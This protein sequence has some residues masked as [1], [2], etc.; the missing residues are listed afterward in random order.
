MKQRSRAGKQIIWVC[1]VTFILMSVFAGCG[2]KGKQPEKET[3]QPEKVPDVHYE[4]GNV[5]AFCVDEQ[6]KI[7][8]CEE[9]T[10]TINVYDA[11][12]TKLGEIAVDGGTEAGS[13]Y[14]VL[15]A[16]EGVLYASDSVEKGIVAIDVTTGERELLYETQD[17]G[18]WSLLDM[19]VSNGNLYFIYQKPVEL[20][21]IEL[22]TDYASGYNYMGERVVCLE[23][24]T[25]KVEELEVPGVKRLCKKSDGELLFY[26]YDGEN[27]FSYRVYDTE[28]G[29]YSAEYE[30]KQ[31]LDLRMSAVMT[32]DDS[33]ER[34]LYPDSVSGQLRAIDIT[35]KA[36][37]TEFYNTGLS[38]FGT[39]SLQC[40]NG[41]T[42]FVSDGKVTKI[43]NSSYIMENTPLK[44]CTVSS[45]YKPVSGIGYEVIVE[46]LDKETIATK[47]LAGDSDFDL[48]ILSSE[49]DLAR[50]IER[51]GAYEPLNEV[52]EVESYLD[53]CFDYIGD[54]ATADN[55]A[56]WML[57]YEVDT[58]VLIYQP[59]VCEKYGVDFSGEL[60][61]SEFI[62][63]FKVLQEATGEDELYIKISTFWW[64]A[65]QQYM[66]NYGV[67]DGEP[68]FDTNLFRTFASKFKEMV[69]SEFY[70]GEKPSYLE[71]RTLDELREEVE[72][73]YK[74][75]ALGILWKRE[76][77]QRA[78]LI[79][80]FTGVS[81]TAGLFDYDFFEARSMPSIV[82]GKEEKGV[83][84][85]T[86]YVVNPNSKRKEETM[87][88]LAMVAG[89]LEETE[90]IYRT[91]ELIGEYSELEKQV[92]DVYADAEI[93]FDY[94][95]EV[96]GAEYMNYMTGE[97]SLEDMIQE[98]ERKFNIY[99]KE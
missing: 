30:A 88:Y 50:Q 12:G 95:E 27:G 43:N 75:Y 41:C 52:E 33:M 81:F 45:L 11:E 20:A 56:V 8:T 15:C 82:G 6:E 87:E 60:T 83:A 84:Y 35:K 78:G 99:L 62:D 32:Y 64:Q 28:T 66:A 98:A 36:S 49:Y 54:A 39:H 21:E 40:T 23:L 85:T 67:E 63:N 46:E 53:S 76:L 29:S 51:T 68:Q 18:Y 7:Y 48:M 38:D 65:L 37:E 19:T 16:G 42:Y 74:S 91:E 71:V 4:T 24:A 94:P 3:G 92:H 93:F 9:G 73:F 47:L 72:N 61:Y 96:V 59:D 79:N 14:T 77:E 5:I 58:R 31:E 86:F 57:P 90:S 97:S 44:I 70:Y 80:D 34:L 26:A 69:F 89:Y 22:L 2:K 10:E 1:V 55:G 13:R 17:P 25:K